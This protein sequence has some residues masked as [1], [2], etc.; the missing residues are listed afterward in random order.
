MLFDTRG[1]GNNKQKKRN[2]KNE[3]KRK[4]GKKRKRKRGKSETL[5][6]YFLIKMTITSAGVFLHNRQKVLLVHQIVSGMWSF[7]KGSKEEGEDNYQCWKRELKE[8]TGIMKIPVHRIMGSINFLKYNITVV[9][10][11]TFKLPYPKIVKN[12]EI[13][14]AI[15]I[16][17][18][19]VG[20]LRLNAVTRKILNSVNVSNP[21]RNFE[22]CSKRSFESFRSTKETM[23]ETTKEVSVKETKEV[24]VKE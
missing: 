1:C 21:F 14:R 4:R 16:D 11:N 5:Y 8:E 23:K 13:D 10:L 18:S 6:F 20:N 7:P 2:E 22:S 9:E 12:P 17:I 15:W 24:S 3:K 19:K